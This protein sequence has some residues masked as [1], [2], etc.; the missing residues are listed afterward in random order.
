VNS[1]KPVEQRLTGRS[2]TRDAGGRKLPK[3]VV[4]LAASSTVPKPPGSLG[5]AGREVWG[6]LWVAGQA[7]L[8]VETD[9]DVLTRLCEAHDERDAMREQIALDGFMVPGSRGQLRPH[10]L[11]TH[12]RALETQMT[13]WE[14]V[15]GFTPSARAQLGHAEVAR[16][17]QLNELMAKR[18]TG[19]LCV[20][21]VAGW[22][23]RWLMP[24]PAPLDGRLAVLRARARRWAQRG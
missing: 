20:S 10:P 9:R 4:V 11:L 24:A 21:R 23:P 16:V 19:R 15:C 13:H 22:P 8:S 5:D 17:S 12:L 3:P 7:W 18:A 1:P 14:S 2:A 6:R